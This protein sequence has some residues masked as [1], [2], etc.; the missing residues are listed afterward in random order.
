MQLL[1]GMKNHR[2][3]CLV[4]NRSVDVCEHFG[5]SRVYVY[6]LSHLSEC[7]SEVDISSGFLNDVGGVCAVGMA[8]EDA[9]L[10]RLAADL[11]HALGL[12]HGPSLS[13]GPV[14]C[15]VA[16]EF[17]P[18][19]LESFLGGSYGS[20]FRRGEDGGRNDVEAYVVVVAEDSVYDVKTLV[21]CGMCQHQTSVDIA[22]GVEGSLLLSSVCVHVSRGSEMLID[23]YAAVVRQGNACGLEVEPLGV[24]L[25]PCGHEDD[26]GG[27]AFRLSFLVDEG[28]VAV[29]DA[30]D[31][32][33]HAEPDALFL[34]DSAQALGDVGVDG[35]EALFQSF[36]DGHFGA[37]AVEDAGELQS[38]D[39][40]S[41]DAQALWPLFQ[42]EQARGI[43]DTGE[44]GALDR[45]APGGGTCGDDD[46]RGSMALPAVCFDGAG[47]DERG[48]LA[49]ERD[50]GMREQRL[51]AGAQ[52]LHH[53]RLPPYGF[54]KGGCVDV[55]LGGYASD[56]EA[57]AT[58]KVL[59]EE[60]DFQSVA[61]SVEGALVASGACADDD[62]VCHR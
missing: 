23:R 7:S 22:Y 11:D 32:A 37:E 9:S 28:H 43:D 39:A 10:V 51:H 8:A 59:F 24:G 52:L 62:E 21:L 5:K 55:G 31:A 38:Y 16:L 45:D 42:G 30:S 58:D 34:H 35:R 17:G 61:C 19:F 15:L 18:L 26:I 1:S 46:V 56:I 54:L 57:R 49:H 12:V 40:S 2:S 53:L 20:G 27:D 6:G 13:V 4:V 50:I 29:G 60:C 47:I 48:S 25:A 36:H 41:D 44:V 3:E 14:G 33:L